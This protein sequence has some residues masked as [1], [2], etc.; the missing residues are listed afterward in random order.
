MQ[1]IWQGRDAI[2][3]CIIKEIKEPVD[4]QVND[5]LAKKF[6]SDDLAGLK[7]Q[8]AER[9]EAEY[10]GASKDYHEAGAA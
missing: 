5:E 1:S 9:L 10:A 7:V 2:F 8:I 3:S 6:G 4:A